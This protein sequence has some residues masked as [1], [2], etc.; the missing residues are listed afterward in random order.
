MEGVGE[1]VGVEKAQERIGLNEGKES[2][3]HRAWYLLGGR[4]EGKKS[5]TNSA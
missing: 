1:K 5:G 2:Q 3:A 4:G